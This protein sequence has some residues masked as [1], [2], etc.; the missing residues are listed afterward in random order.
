MVGNFYCSHKFFKDN[1]DAN[2]VLTDFNAFY[3]DENTVRIVINDNDYNLNQ[4]YFK[5]VGSS[6]NYWLVAKVVKRLTEG[7]ELILKRDIFYSLISPVFDRMIKNRIPFSLSH[8]W[9][10][11]QKKDYGKLVRYL[12]NVSFEKALHYFKIKYGEEIV[13]ELQFDLAELKL[14]NPGTLSEVRTKNMNTYYV[15]MDENRPFYR[16]IPVDTQL[17]VKNPQST[18]LLYGQTQVTNNQFALNRLAEIEKKNFIGHFAGPNL[19]HFAQN[20]QNT[21]WRFEL[22]TEIY[23]N[24]TTRGKYFSLLLPLNGAKSVPRNTVVLPD[25]NLGPDGFDIADL[26]THHIVGTTM[27]PY[28]QLENYSSNSNYYL[29]FNGGFSVIR[30]DDSTIDNKVIAYYGNELPSNTDSFK[31]FLFQNAQSIR[32]SWNAAIT[33]AT[34]GIV[35]DSLKILANVAIAVGSG[36]SSL[37]GDIVKVGGIGQIF[38]GVAGIANKATTL[39]NKLNAIKASISDKQKQLGIEVVS[40]DTNLF[41]YW[42]LY[43]Y[44]YIKRLKFANGFYTIDNKQGFYYN[45]YVRADLPEELVNEI[46]REIYNNGLEVN[47]SFDLSAGFNKRGAFYMKYNLD[48]LDLLIKHHFHHLIPEDAYMVSE[49]LKEGFIYNYDHLTYDPNNL[50]YHMVHV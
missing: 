17:N 38:K 45:W 20:S 31:T 29:N 36:G 44:D 12:K 41:Y 7:V 13:D 16:L 10:D 49:F 35:V 32:A 24:Q 39:T 3:I 50:I 28:Y 8:L 5:S 40:M 22:D 46:G 1:Y 14:E 2:F 26:V 25:V 30:V 4:L 42:L 37:A 15:F 34:V 47:E 27:I 43:N 19:A 23:N 6:T 48:H 33:T 18:N 11:F 21:Y 9:L